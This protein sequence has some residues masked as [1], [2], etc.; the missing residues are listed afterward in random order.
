MILCCVPLCRSRQECHF[1]I[2]NL[3]YGIFRRRPASE[4]AA[5]VAIGDNVLDLSVLAEEGLL[6]SPLLPG[7]QVFR[8]ATLNALMALGRPAWHEARSLISRLLRA[9]EPTLR[10][11]SRVAERALV[12]MAEVDMLLPASIGDYTDFYSSREHATNVGTMLLRAE[13]ALM[14]NWLYLPVA[15]HG[16][17]SSIVVSGT[18]IHRPSGQSKA[19][20]ATAPTFGPSRSVDFELETGFFIGPG[21]QLG[22]PTPAETAPE[23]LFG[24]VLVNDWRRAT[25]RPGNTCRSGRSSPRILP[26]PSLR[27]L[28]RWRPWSRFGLQARFKNHHPFRTCEPPAIAPMTSTSKSGCKGSRWISRAASVGPIFDICTGTWPSNSLITPSTAAT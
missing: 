11:N 25:S 28:C 10:D 15:Y 12:P 27:G 22:R 2:Q 1:P 17:A 21:N 14:P 16:R 26:R 20:N 7:R 5:G 6:D 3:P 4:P 19:A 9:E 24:I 13:N 23:H 8:T 18:D